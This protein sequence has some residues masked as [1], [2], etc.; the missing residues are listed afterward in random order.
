MLVNIWCSLEHILLIPIF[1]VRLL[2]SLSVKQFLLYFFEQEN[3]CQ[4]LTWYIFGPVYQMNKFP[5][6]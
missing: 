1:S 3:Y 2:H 4:N 5:L 6:R